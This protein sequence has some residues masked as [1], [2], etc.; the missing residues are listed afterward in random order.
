MLAIELDRVT[1]A[2]GG[3]PVL[4][5]VSVAIHPGEFIGVFGSNGAGKT[6]LLH[7]ILGLL[8]PCAGEIKVLGA[9]PARGN[10]AAGY[11]PQH[12]TSVADLHLRGWDFVASALHGERWG[13]ALTGRAGKREVERAIAT[14][15]AQAL[16]A[17]P[18]C[19]LSGGELQRLLLAQAL[20]GKPKLLL[21]DEPLLS[22]DPHFQQA[23][24]ALVKRVQQTERITVLF[25]AHE[26]NPLLDAMDRVL[27]LG[28]GR[29][30]LGPVDEVITGEVLSRLYGTPIE[31]LRVNGRILVVAGHGLVEADA[32]RHDV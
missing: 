5:D 6:T 12:R 1:L 13:L 17:R 16:A 20:L 31:V 14:V 15:E 11:L 30:A 27:Y 32:H 8:R 26:L 3:Q 22:L 28:Q 23:T 10:P 25:T 2:R 18:L 7:A 24:V 4:A 9:P 19:Q 21:L 29:A